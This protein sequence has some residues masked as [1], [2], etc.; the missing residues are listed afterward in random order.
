MDLSLPVQQAV[1]EG[2][3]NMQ[4][5]RIWT[6][7]V[8]A[9]VAATLYASSAFAQNTTGSIVG[10]APDQSGGV[11]PN[12]K[13]EIKPSDT[14]QACATP[15]DDARDFF[16]VATKPKNLLRQS[17]PGF[18]LGGPVILLELYKGGGTT[19]FFDNYEGQGI[20]ESSTRKDDVPASESKRFV[21]SCFGT[22]YLVSL[23]SRPGQ[24]P[25]IQ[26]QVQPPLF[27][28]FA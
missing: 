21:S 23:S 2:G 8:C 17:L 4:R 24:V 28:G 6:L 14:G 15:T 18:S 19:F 11:I 7:V 20:R 1:E 13:V 22:G 9:V 3:C 26:N 27:P 10:Q 16:N 5:F 12:A 25:L